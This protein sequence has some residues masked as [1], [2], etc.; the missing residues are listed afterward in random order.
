MEEHKFPFDVDVD[1][2][3]EVKLEVELEK[4]KLKLSEIKTRL[5]PLVLWFFIL[6]GF[7][8]LVCLSFFSR[9]SAIVSLVF[10]VSFSLLGNF[11]RA[12]EI[13][14]I[15]REM[16]SARKQVRSWDDVAGDYRKAVG[17]EDHSAK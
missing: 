8:I 9:P 10:A 5:L 7:G 1:L 11:R 16:V 2:R 17:Q 4:V 13:I 12:H 3:R 14:S 6:L 15:W